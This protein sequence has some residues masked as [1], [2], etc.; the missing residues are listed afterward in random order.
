MKRSMGT[1]AS[2]AVRPSH[3]RRLDRLPGL[4][5]PLK[6]SRR[7]LDVGSFHPNPLLLVICYGCGHP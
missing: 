3:R 1:T 2:L 7:R 4:P 6:R 5:P